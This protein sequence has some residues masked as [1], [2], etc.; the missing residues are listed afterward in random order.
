MPLTAPP[1]SAPQ[2]PVSWGELIDKITIL[3]I[4]SERIRAKAALANVRSE[5][6][7]LRKIAEPVLA[8]QDVVAETQS[9]L[10]AINERLWDMEDRL[11]EKE[12]A[13]DFGAEFVDLARSVY[14]SNDERAVLKRKI[15][16]V[17]PCGIV[18]EK[19]YAGGT[20]SNS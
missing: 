2:I 18:E 5:L 20:A 15:N 8:A 3:E 12:A 7:L 9:Q 1:V 16:G 11:R 13:G 10:R 17:L 6:A 14:R 19:S 4:K